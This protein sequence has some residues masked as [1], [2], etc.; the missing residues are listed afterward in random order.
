[1]LHPI[2]ISHDFAAS[3]AAVWDLVQDFGHIE[4]WWPTDD[5]AVQ[6]DR[7]D[8]VGEG[9]GMIRHIYNKGYPD[10]VSERL[11]FL[12]PDTLTYRLNI[13]GKAPMGITYYQATGRIEELPGGGCRLTYRSEFLSSQ[14]GEAE[15]WLRMAYGLMFRGLACAVEKSFHCPIKR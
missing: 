3:P 11:E 6:I 10:P 9:F 12:D 4:R 13:V 2:T 15:A 14:P 8:I 5:P 7:V 1:M